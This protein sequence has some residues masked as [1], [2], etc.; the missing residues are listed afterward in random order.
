M[1]KIA[2][3]LILG[4]IWTSCASAQVDIGSK[5]AP[6]TGLTHEGK[7]IQLSDFTEKGLVLVYFF[8]KAD[9]PG[10]TKQACS[11][12]DAYTKLQ[13]KGVKIFGVS[14]D[15]VKDLKAFKEKYR[16]PF[17]FISDVNKSW[18][19]AFDVSVTFGFASRQAFLLKEGKILWLDRS[20]STAEQAQDVLEVLSKH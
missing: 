15:G 16:L 19:K 4:L 3:F 6:L 5:I 20:A 7:T 14:T 9:T 8:P 10:C 17:D 12:R 1:V 11:L 13:A 18:A 2:S